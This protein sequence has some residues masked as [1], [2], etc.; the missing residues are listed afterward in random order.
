M[1]ATGHILRLIEDKREKQHISLQTISDCLGMDISRLNDIESGKY[2]ITNEQLSKLIDV[3]NTDKKLDISGFDTIKKTGWDNPISLESRR[4]IGSKAKLVGWIMNILNSETRDVHSFFDVFAGTGVVTKVALDYF[5]SVVTNDFLYSN[6]VIYKAFFGKGSID[7]TKIANILDKYNAID[8]K[9]LK[10]NY[11]SINFGGKYFQYDLAKKVGYIR[12]DIENKK[13]YLSKKEYC[14]LIATL[15]YNIDRFANTVGHFDA[16]IKKTIEYKPLRLRMIEAKSYDNVDIFQEDANALAKN[17]KTD[18]AYIDPPYNSRQ[19]SRFYHIYETLTKWDKPPLYGVALKPEAENMSKYCT[20]RAA[21]AF[22]DLIKNLNARYIA[23]SY[24]NT[25]HSKSSSS[26]NKITLE[27][28]KHILDKYGKTHIYECSH[29]FFN[30][31]KTDFND[32]KELLFITN[33]R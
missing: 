15:I 1:I 18:V 2:S 13:P 17:I 29:K 20:T 11:F 6:N 14:T 19:Y 7:K 10:D 16:Y 3:C 4:Y 32:H 22:E 27:Q 21:A 23:V 12:E 5:D 9:S 25:Y 33:V 28:L 24:N 30:T 31:G 8:E 26:Q